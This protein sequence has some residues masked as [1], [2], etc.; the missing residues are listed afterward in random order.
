M[1]TTLYLFGMLCLVAACDKTE[2][3]GDTEKATDASA[4]AASPEAATAPTPEPEPTAAKLSPA[5]A[6]QFLPEDCM[7]RAYLD[8]QSL[9]RHPK[10]AAELG[11]VF[12]ALLSRNARTKKALQLMTSTLKEGGLKLPEDARGLAVCVQSEKEWLSVA[13]LNV[14]HIKTDPLGLV[15]KTVNASKAAE[16]SLKEEGDVPYLVAKDSPGVLGFVADGVLA[17]AND[18]TMLT[19]AASKPG[20]AD[21]FGK[22][23]TNMLVAGHF[24]LVPESTVKLHLEQK[25]STVSATLDA[26]LTKKQAAEALEDREKFIEELKKGLAAQLGEADAEELK[27]LAAKFE[28][29]SITI[30]KNRV[31]ISVDVSEENVAGLIR[32]VVD[33]TPDRL[34]KEMDRLLP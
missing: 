23:L 7:A 17:V 19:K 26:S 1:R 31:R 27:S 15:Q 25:G 14:E 5:D 6:V 29:A 21:A 9:R 4:S 32:A 20:K 16:F 34:G 2:K 22:E 33:A 10:A 3:K 28:K 18:A 11:D 12:G 24:S 13:T 30:E 8:I